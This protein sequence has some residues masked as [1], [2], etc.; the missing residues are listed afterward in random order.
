MLNLKSQ[1]GNY[2]TL[3]LFYINFMEVIEIDKFDHFRKSLISR[4]SRNHSGF[5]LDLRYKEELKE[6]LSNIKINLDTS[7]N[8]NLISLNFKKLN[9]RHSD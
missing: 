1:P 8:G 2:N 6:K 7:G 3:K 5:G 4:F 9:P